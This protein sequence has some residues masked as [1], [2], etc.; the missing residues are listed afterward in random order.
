MADMP[1]DAELMSRVANGEAPAFRLLASRH[2]SR[3]HAIALRVVHNR[4]D[5]EEVVQDALNK[6]WRYAPVFDPKKSAFGTWFYRI[7]TNAAL[8][9]LRRRPPPADSLDDYSDILPDGSATGETA[10]LR[11]G[12]T[13]RIQAALSAL[14]EQQ[15]LAVVLCYYED[16]TQPE[17]AR[18]MKLNIKALEGLLFRARKALKQSL[19]VEFSG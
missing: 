4:E 2:L 19:N 11:A 10:W 13:R 1:S 5:A 9:R 16:F 14:P 17:A 15:R 7:L 8:D 3:A 6:V 12:E 18:I